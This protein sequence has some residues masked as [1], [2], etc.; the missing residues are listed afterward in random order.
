MPPVLTLWGVGTARTLRP[1]W[2]L[3]ELGLDY[4]TMPLLPRT[5]E[6]KT[7]EFTKLNP[8]QK[9]PLLRDGDFTIGESAAIIA[10]LAAVY[11]GQPNRLIPQ[12][13]ADY[14][15]WLEWC[16][17]IVTELDSTSLY[18]MRRH[19]D[20]AHLYGDAPGVV[21]QAG[22][23]FLNQLRHVEAALEDGREFIVGDRF[24]TADILLATCLRW[25]IVY[26]VGI[27]PHAH[28]YLDRIEARPAFAMACAA[29]DAAANT[30]AQPQ[31]E[32]SAAR[33]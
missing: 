25:G 22:D 17:F 19:S 4:Q 3:A 9:L 29:N 18:V 13:D 21:Q 32:A 30:A 24:T 15:H 7:A 8:R 26:K 23:Y 16:F 14:A 2:A 28:A 10:Y 31:P 27:T 6:T 33:A 20:L 11:G 12:S 5:G 1:H